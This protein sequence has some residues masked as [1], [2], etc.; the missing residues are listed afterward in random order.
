MT[1]QG[2][3]VL[4]P[5]SG[6]GS[7]NIAALKNDRR[8]IGIER[9]ADYCAVA[10]DRIQKFV[11][12]ELKIRAMGKPVHVPTGRDKVAQLPLEWALNTKD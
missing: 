8:S 4:D 12:G 7:T 5:F 1:D 11:G 10:T 3:W 6:V 2:D 9:D